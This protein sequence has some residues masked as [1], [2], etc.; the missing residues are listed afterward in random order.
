MREG[1]LET[2]WNRRKRKQD[3]LVATRC[4]LVEN[5]LKKE[6]VLHSEG[7]FVSVRRPECP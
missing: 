2:L 1:Y 4:T 7:N 3:H 5:N 6:T